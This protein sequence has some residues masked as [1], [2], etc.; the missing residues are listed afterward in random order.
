VEIIPRARWGARYPNGF[1]SSPL[2][3]RELWLHHSVTAA[4]PVDASFEQDA[5]AVRVLEDIGQERF[6]GGISYTFAV[7]PS[8]RIFE[9]HSVGRQGAHTGGRND[10]ARAIVL[11]GDYS[12]RTPTEAQRRA[13][14]WL[15]VHGH[16]QGWWTV[17]GLSG[18][19]RQAP[20]QI[21]TAC[22]GDA[23]LREIPDINRLAADYAAG[24]TNL[25]DDMPLTP[26]DVNLLLYGTPVRGKANLA[27]V[28]VAIDD[29]AGLA[30]Q[31]TIALEKRL[32]V[33][34]AAV[35]GGRVPTA[36]EIAAELMPAVEEI[37]ERVAQADNVEQAAEVVR[38]LGRVLDGANKED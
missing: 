14:A 25:E 27:Q 17:A 20:N 15:V 5:A 21:A 6:G 31:R 32:D 26:A 9:G 30:Y 3:A 38:Q 12:T 35:G 1:T 7:T 23:A 8:G 33:L 19:H 18:G 37:A 13:V 29:N 10:I 24:R 11:V 36:K 4:P 2:P 22:P 28:L 34:A 16:R